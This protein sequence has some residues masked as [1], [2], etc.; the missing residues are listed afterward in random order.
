MTWKSEN[1]EWYLPSQWE[2]CWGQFSATRAASRI[3][4][5]LS[6]HVALLA[7]QRVEQCTR[8]AERNALI[9]S[10][11]EWGMSRACRIREKIFL[12]MTFRTPSRMHNC[13]PTVLEWRGDDWKDW[14]IWHSSPSVQ[15]QATS[16][17]EKEDSIPWRWASS[18]RE[19]IPN[20]SSPLSSS[21]KFSHSM[22][23]FQSFNRCSNLFFSSRW[24]LL[25]AAS[26]QTDA[27][28]R[29][30]VSKPTAPSRRTPKSIMQN[31]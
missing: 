7:A 30:N 28:H 2:I 19:P 5:W 27:Q 3:H 17:T 11:V 29:E 6:S 10:V 26:K 4:F 21:I 20:L 18:A 1:P 9:G 12:F 16:F 23:G 15:S 13:K 31:I 14:T 25:V 8:N 22:K 24:G